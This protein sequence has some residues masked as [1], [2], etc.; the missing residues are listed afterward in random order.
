M[1]TNWTDRLSEY[2]DGELGR[3]A[4]EALEARLAEDA[5]LRATLN[6]LRA[7]KS[8]AADGVDAAPA[9][10]LW[11]GVRDRIAV[12]PAR[13]SRRI[14]TVTIPQFAAAA[15]V[16]LLLGVGLARM[17]ADAR[18]GAAS[19]D[20]VAGVETVPAVRFVPASYTLFV[21][22]LEDRIEAGKGLLD[23]KTIRVLE[24]SLAKMDQ[25]I[26]QAQAALEADPNNTYLNQHLASARARKLRL[27]ENA[28]ALVASST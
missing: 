16:M 23:G 13:T 28:T 20:A 12:S 19:G 3:G 18:P 25:A 17:G 21:E 24:Q 26:N 15:G 27:L 22:D 10:D 14:I 2:I 7:V 8:A 5:E 4:S 6:E 11:P 1:N 9:S